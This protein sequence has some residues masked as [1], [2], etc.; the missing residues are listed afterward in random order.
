[1]F[2][3]RFNFEDETPTTN[4]DTFPAA[5]LTVFQVRPPLPPPARFNS[6]SCSRIQNKWENFDFMEQERLLSVIL[7]SKNDLSVYL[8]SPNGFT[9]NPSISLCS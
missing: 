8:L 5:I 7:I 2:S 6:L 4:F 9:D 1:M 3:S